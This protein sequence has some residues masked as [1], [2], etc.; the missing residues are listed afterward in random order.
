M[1]L[2]I[3]DKRAYIAVAVIYYSNLFILLFT[4]PNQ[5]IFLPDQLCQPSWLQQQ[6]NTDEALQQMLTLERMCSF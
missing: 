1:S 6:Q 2:E 4:E 3:P 5:I